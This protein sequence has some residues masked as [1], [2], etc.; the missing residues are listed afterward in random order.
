MN[1]AAGDAS[2][3]HGGD[4]LVLAPVRTAPFPLDAVLS[5]RVAAA[6]DAAILR[7]EASHAELRSVVEA[8]VDSLRAQGMTPEGVVITIKSVFLHSARI[9]APNRME[10]RV[11]AAEYYM[12]DVVNW[13][14]VAY[15]RQ[16]FEP[17]E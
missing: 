4:A 14:V 10:H 16:R 2:S 3:T 6:L 15:F 12:V 13:S 5:D 7:H 8:C 11:N 17:G 1:G 9:A